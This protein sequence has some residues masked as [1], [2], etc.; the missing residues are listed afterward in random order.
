MNVPQRS[1]LGGV[2]KRIRRLIPEKRAATEGRPYSWLD[3]EFV[4]RAGLVRA[5]ETTIDQSS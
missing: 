4:K 3:E 5:L 1:R 2:K